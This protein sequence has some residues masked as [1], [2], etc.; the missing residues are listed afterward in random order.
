M[1]DLSKEF[2]RRELRGS[3]NHARLHRSDGGG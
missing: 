1:N 3:G 2:I